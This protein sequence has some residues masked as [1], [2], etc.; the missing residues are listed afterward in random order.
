[1]INI[2]HFPPPKQRGLIIH[3]VIILILAVIAISAFVQLSSADVGLVFLSA[4]LIALASFTPIPF[5]LYR[6]Y[7]L[8]RA[9]YYLSRDSLRINWGLRIEDIPLTDI[10]WIRSAADLTHPVSLPSFPMPGGILG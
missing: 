5:F 6:L 7:S 3:G 4:L 8:W 10:E 2:G 9:D 1:M